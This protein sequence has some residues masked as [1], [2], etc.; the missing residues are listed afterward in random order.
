MNKQIL[1]LLTCFFFQLNA[2]YHTAAGLKGTYVGLNKENRKFSPLFGAIMVENGE[3]TKIYNGDTPEDPLYKLAHDLFYIIPNTTEIAASVQPTNAASLLN[4]SLIKQL[5]DQITQNAKC[6]A[7]IPK[8]ISFKKIEPESLGKFAYEWFSLCAN[9]LAES[10]LLKKKVS[11]Y[12][13]DFK[14]SAKKLLIDIDTALTVPH[15]AQKVRDIL[16]AYV[17]LK[18]NST[19]ELQNFALLYGAV[20]DGTAF[21][22]DDIQFLE[23]ISHKDFHFFA[24]NF[25]LTIEPFIYWLIQKKYSY[26]NFLGM[27][28]SFLLMSPNIGFPNCTEQVTQTLLNFLLYNPE[29]K[30]LDPSLLPPS[31]H[32]YEKLVLFLRDH[33]DPHEKDYGSKTAPLWAELLSTIPEITHKQP[34]YE[35][36]AS[37][38]NILTLL[39]F[40]C[41]IDAVS[42]Q[43]LGKKLTTPTRHITIIK[44]PSDNP[45]KDVFKLSIEYKNFPS[46]ATL[47]FS[48]TPE[49]HATYTLPT[50]NLTA[51]QRQACLFAGHFLHR[52]L[53]P[54]VKEDVHD[55]FNTWLTGS[56]SHPLNEAIRAIFLEKL[57]RGALDTSY[58]SS[59][60]Q[61][62]F[63]EQAA[64]NQDL[65]LVKAFLAKEPDL[66]ARKTNPL[67]FTPLH[68]A[69]YQNTLPL[70]L[71]L[72]QFLTEAGLSLE[73]EN[74]LHQTPFDYA[75]DR[76]EKD[77][78]AHYLKVL[79]F[80]LSLIKENKHL[81]ELDEFGNPPLYQLLRDHHVS[82]NVL[83]AFIETGADPSIKN[84]HQENALHLALKNKSAADSPKNTQLL[85]AHIDVNATDSDA[86]TPLQLALENK[87]FASAK[88]LLQER[89]IIAL[90]D[91]SELLLH[92]LEAEHPDPELLVSF[93]KLLDPTEAPLFLNH[94]RMENAPTEIQKILTDLTLPFNSST[95]SNDSLRE[96]EEINY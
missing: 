15:K 87:K 20:L 38:P 75:F 14:R 67:N 33:D 64:F 23:N 62:T 84:K 94:P 7:L 4:N 28:P 1:I 9:K 61:S 6:M 69:L 58:R 41:G 8:E 37:V 90:E 89:T 45:H 49:E 56:Q 71:E 54:I 65:N 3:L 31:A 85:A 22:E 5:L 10:H 73:E 60:N 42:L 25:S 88:T 16:L 74:T 12:D 51:E 35:I 47:L 36:S 34:P 21:T 59:H 80:L 76:Y 24:Q 68:A 11:V 44:A 57:N 26:F 48:I 30:L 19:H 92:L 32:P 96:P 50:E 66:I 46:H 86:K 91:V 40:L 79:N 13:Q 52:E 17:Y 83:A 77:R 78:S 93:L 55:F 18:S 72:I 39:N 43:N 2:D 27:P 82:H 81:S 53:L 95:S 63:F 70:N 29:T